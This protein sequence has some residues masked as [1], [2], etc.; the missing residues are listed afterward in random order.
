MGRRLLEME[1]AGR[2]KRGMPKRRET[3]CIK[4]D[5]AGNGMEER[6]VSYRNK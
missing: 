2:K 4:G 5:V 3:D 6:D 1:V